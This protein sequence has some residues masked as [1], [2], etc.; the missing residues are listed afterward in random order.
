MPRPQSTSRQEMVTRA[1]HVFWRGGFHATSVDAL[2]RGTGVSRGGIYAE[3]GGKAEL[4]EACLTRYVETF[5]TPAIDLLHTEGKGLDAIAAYLDYFIQLHRKHGLPGP[6]C[7]I[8]NTMTELAPHQ[9]A[10]AAVVNAHARQL[11]DGFFF[12]LSQVV[13]TGGHQPA[14]PTLRDLASFL[15][16]ATQG[17]W[18]HARNVQDIA[19]LTGFRETLLELLRTRLDARD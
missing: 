4:F 1:M 17:L 7:F 19:V 2:V 11:E 3:H 12:A 5:A 15:V 18:S 16:T 8:A 10:A 9:T 13:E 14:D 6:G